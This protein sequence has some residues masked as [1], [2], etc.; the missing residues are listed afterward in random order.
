M[1]KKDWKVLEQIEDYRNDRNIYIYKQKL[2]LPNNNIIDN[3]YQIKINDFVTMLIQ[4][5]NGKFLC[6]NQYKHGIGRVALTLPGGFIDIGETSLQA[7]KR[8]IMEETGYL[9]PNL[10]FLGK[11]VLSGNQ[12]VCNSHIVS[13]TKANKVCNPTEPDQENPELVLL[14]TKELKQALHDK[15]FPIISHIAAIGMILSK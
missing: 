7:A 11:F 15:M 9:C 5:V 14:S 1:N 6:F 13:G 10:K 12:K 3:F 8:E 2:R 4:D